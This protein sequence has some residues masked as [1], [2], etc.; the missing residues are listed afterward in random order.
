MLLIFK[1][2]IFMPFIYNINNLPC[3]SKW[4]SSYSKFEIYYSY[5]VNGT[6]MF[7][8]FE[9]NL[10]CDG[11]FK[12]INTCGNREFN[13]KWYHSENESNIIL[14]TS[15][16]YHLFPR[17]YFIKSN[18]LIAYHN[19]NNRKYKEVLEISN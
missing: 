7:N 5:L 13:G 6:S 9:L 16:K 15:E 11:T 10:Y 19:Y 17:K 18:K 2:V 8:N 4:I 14:F 1:L 3:D 12:Y